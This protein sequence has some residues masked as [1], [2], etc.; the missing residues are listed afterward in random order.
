MKTKY[1]ILVSMLDDLCDEAPA[2]YKK[3]HPTNEAE[4]PKARG[5]AYIHLLLKIRFGLRSFK[6]RED[7]ITDG[8]NDGGIDA[9]YISH[10]S[11]TI[12]FIQ[13]KFRNTEQNFDGG[14]EISIEDLASM[15]IKEI[16]TP[17][18]TDQITFNGKIKK[19]QQTPILTFTPSRSLFSQIYQGRKRRKG[20]R[21]SRGSCRD[22]NTRSLI[23][24]EHMMNYCCHQF[25]VHVHNQVK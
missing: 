4:V 23:T 5:L 25:P 17:E 19:L 16:V 8:T 9:Y 18:N 14:K 22:L 2:E 12:Y 15:S 21:P 3:Y 6:D 10:A 13:S 24:R 1:E 7:L 20:T 11:H